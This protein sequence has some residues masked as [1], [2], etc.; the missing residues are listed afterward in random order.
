VIEHETLDLE[1]KAGSPAEDG[2]FSGTAWVFGE[3]DA[4][5]DQIIPGAFQKS[6]A[7][8]R[9]AG[10]QPL[11]LWMHDIAEP[12][13]KW[14]DVRETPEGLAV[15]GK[16]TLGTTRAREAY[17]LLKDG[18]LSGL[19]IGFRTLKSVRTK[20]GRLLQELQLEEISLVALPALASARVYTVK[21]QPRRMTAHPL[22]GTTPMS[23]N[24]TAPDTPD[25]EQPYELPPEVKDQLAA[26]ETRTAGVDQLANRLDRIETRLA[27]PNARIETRDDQPEIEQKAFVSWCRKGFDGLNDLE[28]KALNTFATSPSMGGWNLVPETFLRELQR[29]LVE[30]TPM[31]QIARVQTV[32]GNPVLLPKRVY[33]A[34]AAWVAEEAEHAL[35][36]P[37]Y[38]QQSVPVF[39]ARVSV[40]VTN[41]LLEDSAFDLGAELARD[42][43]EE[44][45]RLESVA[46]VMGNGTSEP[47][48]FM[49]SALWTTVGGGPTADGL[50][51]LFYSI[52]TPYSAR[53]T[54]LMPRSVIAT[55]RKLKT[56]QGYLWTESLQPGQPASLLGRPVVE[57][58]DM[59]DTG[60]PT[61]ANI[62]FGDWNRAYRI[63]DRVGLEVLRDPYTAAR[64]SI[65]V[66]HARRRVGGALVDGQAVKGLTT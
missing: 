51:D 42:F 29:T 41:Q 47:E 66:F 40:E 2:T 15:K 23:I 50:I 4:L 61:P 53:G 60:S 22:D 28:R 36:E 49:N 33:G 63:F 45:A 18:A 24:L 16:L 37:A 59:A 55:V 56:S 46:F 64:R 1:L 57:A 12:I 65:V 27:R 35:S 52:P 54:W 9:R 31:R 20:T 13:G 43:A 11:L 6:L 30:F 17:E 25:D 8:H 44:F 26:L 10:R 38:T 19:S 62:G 5:G 32:S 14:L 48:G 3:T 39:E 34:S 7:A 58:P 21:S